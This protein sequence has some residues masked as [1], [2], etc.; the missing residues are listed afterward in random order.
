[1][2]GYLSPHPLGDSRRTLELSR[3]ARNA[4]TTQVLDDRHANSRSAP[5]TGVRHDVA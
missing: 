5:M 4:E 1:M 3:R 2:A